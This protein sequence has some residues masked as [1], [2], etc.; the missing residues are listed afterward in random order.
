VVDFNPK[1]LELLVRRRL[2]PEV[3]FAIG[4]VEERLER[5]MKSKSPTRFVTVLYHIGDHSGLAIMG[6]EVNAVQWKPATLGYVRALPGFA[7]PAQVAVY[8][9]KT[10]ADDVR[11]YLET[12][13]SRN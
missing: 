8:L 10:I 3:P 1:A 4:K 9:A 2:G 12:N 7:S 11:E 6:Q 13:Y 5:D